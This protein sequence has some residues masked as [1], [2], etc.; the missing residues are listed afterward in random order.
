[1]GFAIG[2]KGEMMDDTI[3]R[4]AAIEAI[5]ACGRLMLPNGILDTDA[6]SAIKRV[7]S[8]QPEIIRCKD[9][10]HFEYNHIENVNGIPLI[11][12]H[13]ICMRW[14]DGAKTIENGYCF[15]AERKDD[16]RA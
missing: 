12:A 8:A 16:G 14:G 7:P 1:M 4:Q 15:L 2:Q 5:D 10:K 6:I 11:V 9:C 3:S 13:E